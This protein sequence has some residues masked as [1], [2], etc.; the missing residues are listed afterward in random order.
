MI[1]SIVVVGTMTRY[2]LLCSMCDLKAARMNIQHS[3]IR[4]LRLSE[5]ELANNA[6]EGIKN[7]SCM[8]DE[9][10]VNYSNQTC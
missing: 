2:E 4:E 1:G 8:K 5:I 9:A 6:V 10:A 7:I 3:L